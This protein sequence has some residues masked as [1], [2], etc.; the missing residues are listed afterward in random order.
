MADVRPFKGLR[1]RPE[2]VEKVASPP[3]DVMNADEAREMA[4]DNPLSFLRVVKAEIDFPPEIDS[5]S[6][7]V[8]E[9]GASNLAALEAQGALIR[10]EVPCFYIYELTMDGH[11]Q[12][13]VMLGASADEYERGLIKK[14][15]FTRR[16]KEDDRAHHVDVLN[17][18]T[19]PV[20]LTYR[21]QAA[22]DGTI[23]RICASTSPVYDY[24][25]ADGVGHRMWAVCGAGDVAAIAD[26]FAGVGAFYIADGHHRSAA[27]YRVRNLRRDRNPGHRGDELYNHYLAVA[28]PDDQLQI[29]GYYRAVEALNGLTAE[30]FMERIAGKFEISRTD[31]PQ[32]SALHHFTMYLDGAWYELVA[33]EGSYPA[34]D[35]VGSLDCSIL[36]E[37]LL[38][39]VLGIG[40][41]R[42]ASGIDFIG[43]IRGTRELERRCNLDMKVAF[44]LYPVTVAQL[45]AIS[46][47]GAIMP[48]KST[49]F[50]PKLRSGMVTRSLDDTKS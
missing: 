14:H 4:A 49:W 16:D 10:D 12:K 18:N 29:L 21:A 6:D 17:A 22:L 11:V 33:R 48:P 41:P 23:A 9:R 31:N 13:G 7:E 26:G 15:E 35:P 34:D 46:D 37:N 3:Y 5:H 1:P 39:P 47:A 40:D 2:V 8:Y 24:V 30:D 19:G 32:P 36:Q 50:E 38:S 44:A 45:I 27:G 43:G 28:F 20:M 25:A 42:T